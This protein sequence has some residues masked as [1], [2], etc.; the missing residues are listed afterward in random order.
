MPHTFTP[1]PCLYQIN[2]RCYLTDLSRKT[3]RK[4]TLDDIPDADLDA[5]ARLGFNWVWFLGLWQTGTAGRTISRQHPEWQ[6]EYRRTLP[7]LVVDDVSGSPFAVCAYQLHSDFGRESLTRLRQRLAKRNLRLLV[8]FVPNHVAI[9]H[10]WVDSHPEYFIAG[11]GENLEAEPAN[12]IRVTTRRGEEIFAHGRD[13]YFPGWPDTLQL[14]YR[15]PAL[16][17]AMANELVRISQMADGVRCDMA[18]LVEPEIFQ[19]TWGDRSFPADGAP[20][21]DRPFWPEAIGRVK[22]E[23]PDFLFMA[24]VYWDMEW[25]LMQHGF[26]FT[27]DK[28]LYDRLMSGY[29]EAV[30]GHLH[31]GMDFQ[32]HCV[33]FLE[34]HDEPRVAEKLSGPQAQAAATITTLLPGLT[35]LH[36]G[37][38]EGRL[39]K[40]SPHLGRRPTEPVQEDVRHHYEALL[41]ARKRGS[42]VNGKWKLLEPRPAW[43]ENQTYHQ[44]VSFHWKGSNGEQTWVV[45]NYGPEQGQCYIPL[46]LEGITS[47]IVA[48]QDQ[49]ADIRYD[50]DVSTIRQLGLYLDMPAWGSHAFDI[51]GL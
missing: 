49:L 47:E 20:P 5:I 10:P 31:A 43:V 42:I 51:K 39:V 18:M 46:E 27:Y 36:E 21:T 4:A 11:R 17:E 22:R 34:N 40:V 24:E 16:Q 41:S 19:R 3:G 30:K 38:L 44:F 13:P 14:N 7:D 15:H 23:H 6:E 12:Y 33:R 8:D 32:D 37:Q 25:Q 48:L 2:T 45:V 1:R 28:R 9:D 29:A 35:F 50:R 26:D